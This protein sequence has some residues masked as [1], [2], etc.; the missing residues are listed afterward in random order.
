MGS[1]PITKQLVKYCAEEV[2]RQLDGPL[3]VYWMLEACLYAQIEFT[4]VENDENVSR[5]LH[6]VR[7]IGAMVEKHDNNPDSWRKTDCF[8]RTGFVYP[9][10]Y[11]IPHLMSKWAMDLGTVTPE[12]SYKEFEE[13]HPF[14]DGN[15]RVGSIIY[16][17]LKNSWDKPLTPPDYWSKKVEEKI[18]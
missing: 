12:E 8:S 18:V 7:R 9:S 10:A 1:K 14:V 13:I 16:N 3:H 4:G 11:K 6:V 5:T 17:C 2:F 15:G